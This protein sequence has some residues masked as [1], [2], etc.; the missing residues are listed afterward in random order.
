MQPILTIDLTT[1]KFEPFRIPSSWEQDFL[2]GA[3]LAARILFETLTADL[4]PLSQEAS[5]LFLTGPL[6]GTAGPAVGRFV[7]C[8]KGPA[9][10]IWAESNCGGFWGPK[11]RL[12]GYDGLWISG[13]AQAPV[14]VWIDEEEVQIR[15][16]AGLWGLDAYETQRARAWRSSGPRRKTASCLPVSIA[17]TAAP[18]AGPGWGRSWAPRT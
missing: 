11:L 15:S 3:S 2:G 12:A 18:P 13:R 8:G 9:T 7:V 16:A 14:Y 10:G 1:G 6:T 4:E 17:I 5:L